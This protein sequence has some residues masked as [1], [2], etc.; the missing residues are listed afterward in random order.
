MAVHTWRIKITGVFES[1]EVLAAADHEVTALTKT[2]SWLMIRFLS[3]EKTHKTV[4]IIKSQM[5]RHSYSSSVVLIICKTARAWASRVQA[6]SSGLQSCPWHCTRISQWAVSSADQAL[7]TVHCSF[8]TPSTPLG[9]TRQS[10]G[11]TF[12]DQLWWSCICTLQSPGQRHGTD[13]QQQS[14][15]LTLFRIWLKVVIEDRPV[16]YATRIQNTV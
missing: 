9:S 2:F 14:D 8:S 7:K 5:R 1:T 12:E 11:S 15:H 16:L 3:Q 6:L 10:A 13:Y 4:K